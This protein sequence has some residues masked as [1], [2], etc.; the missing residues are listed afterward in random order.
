[1]E[2][3]QRILG[4]R[5]REAK[6]VWLFFLH[7]FLLG[8][9]TIFLYVA[10][11]VILLD[12]DPARNLP[13]A[14]T[15]SALASLAGGQVYSYF[16]RK[17]ALKKLVTRTLLVAA[18]FAGLLAILLLAGPTVGVAIA[19]LTLYHLIYL[20]TTLEFWGVSAVVFNVR[21][22]RRLFSPISAGDI[23]AKA[24]GAL[25][26]VFIHNQV[27]LPSLVLLAFGAYLAALFTQY[28]TLQSHTA[29]AAKHPVPKLGK[30]RVSF[31]QQLLGSNPMV[32]TM[33]LSMLAVAAVATG[34]EYFFL[35][36]ARQQFAAQDTL[37]RYLG[38][39]L[40]LTYGLA[41]LGKLLLTRHGLDKM[42]L[43]R[44]LLLLPLATLGG[45]LL[46]GGIQA[47]H[48]GPGGYLV[49]FC[50]LY[51]GL[52]VLRR[53]VFSPVFLVLL[54]PLPPA[55]RLQAHTLVKSFFE[56]LGLGLNGLLLMIMRGSPILQQ[57]GP[58]LWMGAMLLGAV[59]LLRRTYQYY[60]TELKAILARRFPSELPQPAPNR[61]ALSVWFTTDLIRVREA[62]DHHEASLHTVASSPEATAPD[63]EMTDLQ[64]LSDADLIHPDLKVRQQ[65]IWNRLTLEPTYAPALDSLQQLVVSDAP[66]ARQAALLLIQFLEPS[67]QAA[68]LNSCLRSTDH[69]L[70]QAASQAAT[71]APSVEV[72]HLLTA[73]LQEKT[74]RKLAATTLVQMGPAALPTLESMLHR[75]TDYPLLRRLA[76]ICAR[77][78]TPGSRHVLLT[79]AQQAHLT[80]R[81]AALHALSGVEPVQAD[82]PLFQ[83]LMQKEMRLA[84]QLLHGMLGANIE[85]RSCLKYELT[86][87]EQRLFSLLL[88]L[89]DRQPILEAKRG[90]ARAIQ[91]RHSNP[92]EALENLLPRPLYH[93]L[94]ALVDVGRLTKKVQ[95]L[96][97]LLGPLSP[98]PIINVILERGQEVFSPWTISVALR[99]WQPTP[100]TVAQLHE[101][102][103]ATNPLVRESAEDVLQLLPARYPA[104]HEHWT[105]LYPPADAPP[106]LPP[107]PPR[108]PTI[109]RLLLLKHT[110]L[111]AETSENVLSN[112]VPIMK[113][114]PFHE[115]Q[116]IFA[117]G[118]LGTSLFII[119]DGEVGI[120]N[121]E[122][123]LATF[124]QGDFFGEL[125]LLDTEPRSATATAQSEVIT[126][127]LDQ[128]DFYDVMEDCDEVLHNILRVLCQRLR[129]QNEKIKNLSQPHPA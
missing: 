27:D 80:R 87:V 23:P 114:V 26:A 124:H 8:I 34:I 51:L 40:A 75:E 38:T 116:Q 84:Q 30:P 108:V 14:Y 25:L 49:Y 105:T 20:L 10:V 117:K 50:G 42:G 65:A 63:P 64:P 86:K 7:N 90:L 126:L 66:E 12:H 125:A 29:A 103:K 53:A 36:S 122:Q 9:G 48:F 2:N 31:W 47:A 32:I 16:E 58:F 61:A 68:L 109:D 6:T 123:H 55:Q 76:G 21:Q 11:T 39:V 54:Q 13:L 22:G 74:M 127:R 96:D 101:Y 81:A 128:E 15:L 56:P 79:L 78:G 111:F 95:A 82:A 70:M 118:D 46:V 35:V 73:L 83:H 113:E 71:R 24:L 120:F 57:W 41:L 52:E 69:A 62:L 110:T 92:L 1:M 43:H 67:Q 88:Q 99:Q 106:K 129:L 102:L 85:L 104:V 5:S 72:V 45:L 77:L 4:V 119:Y 17:L 28:L 93:G 107:A 37:V 59:L 44:T 3:W 121:E 18:G 100:A 97:G 94:Q 89:Y 98:E 91:E 115:G 33:G 112:I 19:L 60:L